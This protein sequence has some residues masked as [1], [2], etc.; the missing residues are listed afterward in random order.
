MRGQD[1]G[2]QFARPCILPTR[3]DSDKYLV[4]LQEVL[5]EHLTDVPALVWPSMWFQQNEA[6]FYYGRCVRDHLDL[7]S[8]EGN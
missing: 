2:E 6:S 3:E 4:F 8:K 7:F 5:P 1:R